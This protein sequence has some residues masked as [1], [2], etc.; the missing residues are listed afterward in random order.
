MALG[1]ASVLCQLFNHNFIST[2][3][4]SGWINRERF[5]L[6]S[7]HAVTLFHSILHLS[8]FSIFI[9][10][11]KQFRQWNSVTL[12]HPEYKVPT[13]ADAS[14]GSLGKGVPTASEMAL[15]EKTNE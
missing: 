4:N 12:G 11:L 10:D 8:G 3:K 13:G 15:D 14:S 7:G 9:E 6:T 5:V 2:P 1:S